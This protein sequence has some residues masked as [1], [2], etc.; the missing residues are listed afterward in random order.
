[1]KKY[2]L[3]AIISVIYIFCTIDNEITG[4]LSETDTEVCAG[5]Y[6][7]LV[8]A[9]GDR[10][11]GVKVTLFNVVKNDS[12]YPI[13]TITTDSNG[14]Y[15]FDDI[16]SGIYNIEGDVEIDSIT[17]VAQI[18]G[19]IYDS[20]LFVDS[21]FFVGVDTLKAPGKIQGFVMFDKEDKIGV[22]VYLPGT[23]YNGFTNSDGAYLISD[24]PANKYKVAFSLDG[25]ITVIDSPVIIESCKITKLDTVYLLHDPNCPPVPPGG[26]SI[27]YD[28]INNDA[29]IKWEPL[30][31]SNII[32]Y[33]VFR[34]DSLE[35][36]IE[37]ILISGSQ[38]I[39]DSVY[40]DELNSPN[41]KTGM[42]LQ[43][44]IKSVNNKSLKSSFSEPVF[45]TVTNGN[46]LVYLSPEYGDTIVIKNLETSIY[47]DWLEY[48]EA[49]IDSI[50]YSFY[51]YSEDS[52]INKIS[53]DLVTTNISL[54]QFKSDV[55]YYWN[56]KAITNNSEYVGPLNKFYTIAKDTSKNKKP[57]IPIVFLPENHST[58]NDTIRFK[59]QGG[60]PDPEDSVFYRIIIAS[61]SLGNYAIVKDNGYFVSSLYASETIKFTKVDSLEFYWYVEATDGI[62]TVK[63]DTFHFTADIA[64]PPVSI[65]TH[66][67]TLLQQ[68]TINWNKVLYGNTIGYYVFKSY[69]SWSNSEKIL[70]SGDSII[71][72]TTFLYSLTSSEIQYDSA[73]YFYVQ[74]IRDD[75]QKSVFS[76]PLKINIKNQDFF[77]PTIIMPD[78]NANIKSDKITF[79]YEYGGDHLPEDSISYEI[80]IFSHR[81]SLAVHNDYNERSKNA[82]DIIYAT[83]IDSLD[84]YWYMS[85]TDGVD[86]LYSDT[87][88]FTVDYPMPPFKLEV[89]Y[90]SSSQQ[91]QLTWNTVKY[92]DIIGYQIY[93]SYSTMSNSEKILISGN[94]L[95]TDTTFLYTLTEIEIENESEICF[96]IKSFSEENEESAFSKPV[97]VNLH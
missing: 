51:L 52:S 21:S 7:V 1:M 82:S 94:D 46:E 97:N 2:L 34:R 64:V 63:T 68:V 53:E 55:F 24:I 78:N 90:N 6:G 45:I 36:A 50:V 88:H 44:Q 20:L 35:T 9:D 5:M 66:Y 11:E 29:I 87:L 37:P 79:K 13:D 65:E 28:T 49:G 62:D 43:Y 81:I 61:H 48:S 42:T 74:S 60:D 26:L 31:D 32:G 19:I 70:I 91:V 67:D 76:H 84:F 30:L 16:S 54:N 22:S 93:K 58:T 10:I 8:S 18:P 75:D 56:V 17:Y 4:T 39:S 14:I 83:Q 15:A 40:K 92:I 80:E 85:A 59:F 69:S 27:L 73:V 95:L 86:T 33:L 25:Y 41:I 89:D 96:L 23:S 77:I 71:I 3:L 72:D 47:F 12:V 38:L 57:L